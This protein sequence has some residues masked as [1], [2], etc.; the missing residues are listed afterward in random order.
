M[1]YETPAK[2]APNVEAKKGGGPEGKGEAS[3]SHYRQTPCI[4]VSFKKKDVDLFNRL[5]AECPKDVS[6][7]EWA[8]KV[9]RVGLDAMNGVTAAPP[10][11]VSR[12]TEPA[13]VDWE[14]WDPNDGL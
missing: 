8:R 14:P 3:S 7:S 12:E 9:L 10:Q 13:P 4:R 11:R 1:A 2:P 5:H 6:F